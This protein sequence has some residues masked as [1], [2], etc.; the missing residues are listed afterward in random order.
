MYIIQN[1]D[2]LYL[3][4]IKKNLYPKAASLFLSKYA[5]IIKESEYEQYDQNPQV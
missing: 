2:L 4:W 5:E 3:H 1:D